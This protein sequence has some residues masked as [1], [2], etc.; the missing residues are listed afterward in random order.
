[1]MWMRD[2][3]CDVCITTYNTNNDSAPFAILLVIIIIII[4]RSYECMNILI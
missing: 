2:G 4:R 1:M 3:V